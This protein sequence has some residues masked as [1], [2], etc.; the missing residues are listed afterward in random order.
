MKTTL[1]KNTTSRTYYQVELIDDTFLVKELLYG[2]E[3]TCYCRYQY[4]NHSSLNPDYRKQ[5]KE[6]WSLVDFDIKLIS[7]AL[8]RS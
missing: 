6:R 2:D 5:Q 1:L 7:K 3:T 4:R 8:V